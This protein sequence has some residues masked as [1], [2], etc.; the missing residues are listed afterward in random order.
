M[1]SLKNRVVIDTDIL[2]DVLRGVEK[3]VA[4]IADL[5]NNGSKLSTTVI[6]A[7]ELYYGAYKSKKKTAEPGRN[8]KIV[9]K[10][11]HP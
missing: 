10:D 1:E 8:E 2:V 5:E 3:T 11:G 9:E 7:F 6:N 4:F